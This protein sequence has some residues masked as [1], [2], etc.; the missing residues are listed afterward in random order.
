[1][2]MNLVPAA[3]TGRTGTTFKDTASTYKSVQHGKSE[4]ALPTQNGQKHTVPAQDGYLQL[5]K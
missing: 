5:M 4:E 2:S 1:M 3:V